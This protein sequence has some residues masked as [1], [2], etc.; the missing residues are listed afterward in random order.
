MN[1][2]DATNAAYE[3]FA[4]LFVLNHSRVLL[5]DKQV[6]G[7]SIISCAFFTSWGFW[8]LYYYPHLNQWLSFIGGLSIT[9]A[10]SIWVILLIHFTKYP[11]GKHKQL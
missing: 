10:N 3:L 5:K 9:L 4:G 6:K 2:Q 1:W 7:V 11:G 8:N